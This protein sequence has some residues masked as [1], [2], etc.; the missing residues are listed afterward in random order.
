MYKCPN[1]L[2]EEYDVFINAGP[3]AAFRAPG[4][5]QGCFALEQAIDE[6]AVKL[7]M[8]PLTLREKI[9]ESPARKV[10]RQIILERT[11]WSKRR[12][13][14]AD[15]GPVKRGMGVAQSVWYRFVDM[16]SSCEVR[17]SRDGSVELLSAVQDLGGGTKTILAQVVAEEFGIPP[18]S[19]GIRIGDTRYPI[20]PNS[21]GSVTAGS[22]TPAVRNAAYQAK[23][24]LLAAAAPS[25]GVAPGELAFEDGRVVVKSDSSRSLTLRQAAGKLTT[26]EIAVRFTRVPDYT[27]EK[28]T[29]GGVDFVELAVDTETGRVHVERVFGAH[30]C[31]RPI[32][33]T[34]VIS[35]I[36]GGML[37]GISYALFEQRI[38]D[39]QKGYM[40]NA[41]LE[42]YKI[43]GARETPEI[44]IALIENYIAQSSTD[45]AGI[46][47]SA[48]VITLAA[49]IGNA[50][51]NA[52]GVRMRKIPMTPANVL[53]ALGT[54]GGEL[55]A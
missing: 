11:A 21:G 48:G 33:P 10:E 52:T 6:L 9:D 3:G 51:Y 46:G 13:A 30:D 26:D 27:K 8:D 53:A 20:G 38:M 22:I 44:E 7:N 31:G 24:Q 45:A 29:Y 36:N 42:N 14:G 16:N 43:L 25:L 15:T 1:L 41:N 37:Q 23:Q 2:T 55:K 32:N 34:G 47:E 49:A 28:L 19:V 18:Q 5:P 40:L 35:Q 12:P 17:V 54:T 4:H 50:F 39:A